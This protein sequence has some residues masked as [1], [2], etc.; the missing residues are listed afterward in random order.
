MQRAPK[1][2]SARSRIVNAPS[3]SSPTGRVNANGCH[4]AARASSYMMSSI[5]FILFLCCV[6]AYYTI[7]E[8]LQH[9]LEL[10]RARLRRH[11]RY[12]ASSNNDQVR[13]TERHDSAVLSPHDG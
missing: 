9:L 11:E 7:R 13:D 5:S 6:P 3:S 4:F 1:M 2:R 12:F 10:G 8:L